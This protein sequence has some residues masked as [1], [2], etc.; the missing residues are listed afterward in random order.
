MEKKKHNFDSI[1]L[2]N[3]NAKENHKKGKN[4]IIVNRVSILL[5]V[6]GLVLL[7]LA[8]LSVVLG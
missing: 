4:K 5:N 6:A 3:Q 7:I 8:S 2:V 1:K